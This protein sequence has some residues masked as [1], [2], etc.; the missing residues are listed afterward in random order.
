MK[1]GAPPEMASVLEEISKE[2][3]HLSIV[4]SIEIGTNPELDYFMVMFFSF[5]EF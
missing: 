3:Q 5:L 4:R 2:N 1:V